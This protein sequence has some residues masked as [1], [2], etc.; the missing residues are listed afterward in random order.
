MGQLIWTRAGLTR[1]VNIGTGGMNLRVFLFLDDVTPDE[2]TVYGD[3]STAPTYTGYV[4]QTP[5]LNAPVSRAPDP[6]ISSTIDTLIF[7]PTVSSGPDLVY[8]WGLLDVA[9][10]TLIAAKRYDVAP[11][12]YAEPGDAR[13]HDGEL[14]FRNEP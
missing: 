13:N 2:D 3:I 4:V 1:L 6:G 7:G 12:T 9:D 5:V 10:N 11:K 14:I 8:G